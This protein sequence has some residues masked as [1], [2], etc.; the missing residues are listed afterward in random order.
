MKIK[1]PYATIA[2]SGVQISS[3]F[4]DLFDYYWFRKDYFSYSHKDWKSELPVLI[5]REIIPWADEI[6][7]KLMQN[8]YREE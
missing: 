7:N 4:E 2:L 5:E 8:R 1:V 3:I 6:N